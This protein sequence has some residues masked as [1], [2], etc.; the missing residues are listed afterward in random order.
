MANPLQEE[1]LSMLSSTGMFHDMEAKVLRGLFSL[2]SKGK[3]KVSAAEIASAASISVTNT[4]KYLY[5][6]EMKGIV[7]TNKE[8]NKLFW[9]SSS[10]N[11]FPRLFSFVGQDYLK[12]KDAFKKME[13]IYER[14]VPTDRNIWLGEK[15]H[16]EYNGNFRERA[17]FLLDIAKEEVLVTTSTALR[18]FIIL[19]AIGRALKRGV[20]VKI[21][22][23]ESDPDTTE[24]LKA[25]GA[26]IRFDNFSPALIVVDNRHGIT[27]DSSEGGLWFLNYSTDYKK[28]FLSHWLSSEVL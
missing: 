10:S 13:G 14:L 4:Y 19:D 6:L 12:K 28:K 20:S 18:D 3:K 21:L 17:A 2:R 5:S 11:P 7:E 9:L 26:D 23:P 22:T 16:S 24:K 8:K 25:L 27:L 15:I 1:L